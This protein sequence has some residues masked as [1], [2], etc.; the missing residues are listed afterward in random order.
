MAVCT[1]RCFTAGL[2]A[3]AA[4]CAGAISDEEGSARRAS[5]GD[6]S[7][8]ATAGPAG[9]P[10][11]GPA[12]AGATGA[13]GAGGPAALGS[14]GLR[15]L[16][17]T[18]YH[19]ALIDLLGPAAAPRQEV[20]PVGALN[21]FTNVG[22][23]SLALSAQGIERHEKV[24]LE[25][26]RATFGEARARTALVGCTPA[27][28]SAAD[29]C[30]RRFLERFGRRAWRRPLEA[31]E[32][33]RWAGVFQAVAAAAGDPWTGLEYAVAGLLQ[34]PHFL[35]RVEL[36]EPDPA[37]RYP[38]RFTAYEMAAR[39]AF[40]VADA[41]PDERLLDAAARGETLALEGL[42]AQLDRLLA[43]PRG[44][45]GGRRFFAEL[46]ETERLDM[47]TKDQRLFPR[48]SPTLGPSMREEI[49]RVVDDLAFV[50]R[51]D[52]RDLFDGRRT[53]VNA[54][55]ARL[56]GLRAP[57]SSG[58]SAAVL[59]DSGPRAGLLGF[60][61]FLAMNARGTRTSPTLRG[62][63]VREQL[64]CQPVPAPPPEAEGAFDAPDGTTTA[65][66]T[67]LRQRLDQHRASPACAG[68]HAL[69]DP[70]GMA[71]ERFDAIGAIRDTDAGLPVDDSGELDGRPFRGLA[72]LAQLLRASPA[73]IACLTRQLFRHAAG[74]V[75]TADEAALLAAAAA[76]AAARGAG[77]TE[78]L[79]AIAT[80]DPFRFA[81]EPAQ[82]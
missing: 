76:S 21:G 78:Y 63:F 46:L 66:R 52:L 35:Y 51:A 77:F 18:E 61:G 9:P 67:T 47:L 54:E 41:P 12:A 25:A 19:N 6:D 36:G 33:D 81:A 65:A 32:V 60:G 22:A 43:T 30:V 69:M 13:G 71:L 40:L 11:T 37:R 20:E 75:E 38:R 10:T 24:A 16:T 70:L 17:A 42:R 3:L 4:G 58:F 55:L 8:P 62:R 23:G 48:M 50:R 64:L 27:A 57:T 44:R 2:L 74:R 45:D 39:L 59:P 56:Y 28:A 14:P 82:Q 79:A 29:P 15:R 73:A 53:F 80:S 34:S 7:W 1:T 72:Q 49:A 31:A 26:A 5:D 68:C